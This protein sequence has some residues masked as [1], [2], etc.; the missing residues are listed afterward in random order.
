MFTGIVLE[1]G[2][3]SSVEA[4]GTVTRLG[5]RSEEVVRDAGI[6]DSIAVNGV[7]LTVTSIEHGVMHFDLSAETLRASN[8]GSLRRGER[9]NLEPALRPSDRLGGH[10]VTGHIDGVGRIR[11]KNRRGETIEIEIEAPGEVLRYVVKKGS[12]A[13]DG[14]SL[15]VVDV[16]AGAFKVVIIPHT[17]R[18]TT[19][20][21]KG[22]GD[23]VN[24]EADILGKYVARFLAPRAAETKDESILNVLGESGFL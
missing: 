2:T 24:L 15:T 18:V 14:I 20:G 9:V 4:R 7:C 11:G 5:I 16:S 1:M 12:I 3:V 19:I 13:I 21:M 6:G 17:E 23:T 22:A 8:I 10:F